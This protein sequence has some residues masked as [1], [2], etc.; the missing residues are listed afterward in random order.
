MTWLENTLFSFF[1]AAV[2]SSI[3]AYVIDRAHRRERR[4][5]TKILNDSHGVTHKQLLDLQQVIYTAKNLDEVK[6]YLAK[7]LHD[8]V[9]S[10][11]PL[12]VI[13]LLREK[14]KSDP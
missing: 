10:L 13:P 7:D 3:M 1:V 12:Q 4:E 14:R 6:R 5:S 9:R 8:L 11:R 2:F